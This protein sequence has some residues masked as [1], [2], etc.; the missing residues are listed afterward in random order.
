MMLDFDILQGFWV[1]GLRNGNV[2]LLSP[3]Q[4]GFYKACMIYAK[5]NGRIVSSR[6]LEDLSVI[7][8]IL[9][10]SPK[11][12]ALRVGLNR[13]FRILSSRTV[14]LFPIVRSWISDWRYIEYL[15][16]VSLGDSTLFRSSS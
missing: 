6:L 2:K 7:I 15:G 14:E 16:F 11:I 13:V 4:R 1:R 12:L 5:I 8:D 10:R 3:I 9:T